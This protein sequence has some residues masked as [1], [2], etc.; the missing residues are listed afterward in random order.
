MKNIFNIK[1]EYLTLIQEVID[2]DGEFTP[3]LLEKVKINE[4]ELQEKAVNYAYVVKKFEY[5][6]KVIDEEINRLKELKESNKRKIDKLKE[7]VLESMR[8]CEIDKI[9]GQTLK[10]SFRK[11]EAVNII[12]ESKISDNLMTTKITKTPN[13]TAIKEAIKE[14]A[15]IK[16]AELVVNINLQIK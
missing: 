4:Q 9:E 10:L 5:D 6:N 16:G 2:N 13:K 8:L 7:I 15:D 1:K 14:G 11:S 12:D 3:E